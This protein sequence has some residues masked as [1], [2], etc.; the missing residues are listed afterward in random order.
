M[1][2]GRGNNVQWV[3]ANCSSWIPLDHRAQ[4]QLEQLWASNSSY[5]IQSDSFRGPLYADLG[6][7]CIVYNGMAY[8]IARRRS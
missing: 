8:T 2:F 6:Q 5:W 7:M 3:Y 4:V 1:A